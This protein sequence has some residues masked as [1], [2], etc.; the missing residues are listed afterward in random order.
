MQHE[1]TNHVQDKT[2]GD[3]STAAAHGAGTMSR[4]E[5]TGED[6]GLFYGL[7]TNKVTCTGNQPWLAFPGGP[8]PRSHALDVLRDENGEPVQ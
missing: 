8:V 3:S 7:F 1:R 2:T 4:Y 5:Y 6:C